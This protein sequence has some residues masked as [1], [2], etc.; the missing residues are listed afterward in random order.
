MPKLFGNFLV[1]IQQINAEQLLCALVHQL[2]S[3]PSTAEVLFEH[4][5]MAKGDQLK[6][7]A[8]QQ[9]NGLDYRTS[10][11]ELGLW[12]PTLAAQVSSVIQNS[13][14]PLGEVLISLGYLK[15]QDLTKALDVYVEACSSETKLTLQ[16]LPAFTPSSDQEV[17]GI[18]S[19][20]G[21]AGASI[22]DPVL[23]AEYSENVST[24]CIPVLRALVSSPPPATKVEFD[25]FLNKALAEVSAIRGAAT[26]VAA[27]RSLSL[28]DE[29]IA[30]ITILK[31]TK[32]I[33]PAAELILLIDMIKYS[34]HVFDGLCQLISQFHSEDDFL[35]DINMK[36]LFERV[37]SL[38][39][40]LRIYAA[41]KKTA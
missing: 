32:E 15:V 7:L 11:K 21:S 31:N 5:L 3:A 10:A 41:S 22:L 27:A 34:A 9:V 8:H 35:S 28:A 2:K 39:E 13:R 14:R 12:N 4:D 26:F 20:V 25:K 30:T 23:S 40:G 6:I 33:L 24:N 29:L 18:P 37:G 16:N 19:N 1:E 36:D 38:Q 17:R